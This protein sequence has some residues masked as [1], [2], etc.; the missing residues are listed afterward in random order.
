MFTAPALTGSPGFAGDEVKAIYYTKDI[1]I[2][3]ESGFP[4]TCIFFLT[5]RIPRK[6]EASLRA[7]PN[8][9]E[10]LAPDSQASLV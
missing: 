9:Q 8:G 10:G 4:N 7:V 2:Q 3:R 1:K 5:R 6:G